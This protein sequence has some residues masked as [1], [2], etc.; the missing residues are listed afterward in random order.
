MGIVSQRWEKRPYSEDVAVSEPAN[1][2]KFSVVAA[3]TR[4]RRSKG[5]V[6][7]RHIYGETD[8]AIL[9]VDIDEHEKA[10]STRKSKRS[11]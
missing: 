2:W 8:R 11:P 5:S 6:E 4:L 7:H 1:S 10:V 9:P 3:D